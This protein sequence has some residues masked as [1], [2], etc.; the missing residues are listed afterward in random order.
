M[1]FHE[2]HRLLTEERVIRTDRPK[3]YVL[4]ITLNRPH[5]RNALT[6][7]MRAQ[8]INELQLADKDPTVRVSI[9]RGDGKDFCAGYD[10]S[11]ELG[12]HSESYNDQFESPGE[13]QFQRAAVSTV[14]FVWDL[15]K[16]V[17]CQVHGHCLAG[18]TEIA[19]A[20][21]VV[22]VAEDAKIG[23][24][25]VRAMGLPDTQAFPWLCGMRQSMELMLSGQAMSGAEAHRT[26]WA[27]RAVPG[28]DLEA[29]CV[30]MA[31][32]FAKVPED[33]QQ[34]NKRSVHRAME[35]M[36]IRT[37]LR[38]GTE[39]QQLSS[40]TEPSKEFMRKFLK[41]QLNVRTH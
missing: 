20:C 13:N 31:E 4:R 33:L 37:A 28:K 11:F 35:C 39:L 12:T 5:K 14:A 3:P 38:Y 22:Y 15:R 34:L 1:R 29:F 19:T 6:P 32:T 40:L 36:G 23:Y 26:G 16:P 8:L 25:P 24:P 17:I 10:V 2:E 21:D 30:K 27:T 9:I 18:G 7:Q 41:D